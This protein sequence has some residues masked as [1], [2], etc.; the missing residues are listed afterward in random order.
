MH[1]NNNKRHSSPP[2]PVGQM[3]YS[4]GLFIKNGHWKIFWDIKCFL[5][6]FTRRLHAKNG[7]YPQKFLYTL[8]NESAQLKTALPL[9]TFEPWRRF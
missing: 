6:P 1:N 7:R 4:A 8:K 5:A 9:M 2:D 3:G